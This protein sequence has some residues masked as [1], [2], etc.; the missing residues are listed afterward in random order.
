MECGQSGSTQPP[1]YLQVSA[2]IS[3]ILIM[4]GLTDH[5]TQVFDRRYQWLER[6]LERVNRAGPLL[7]AEL[8][9][10]C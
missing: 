6:G 10:D 5:F 1:R 7:N 3:F 4:P 2:S 8:G 9:Q